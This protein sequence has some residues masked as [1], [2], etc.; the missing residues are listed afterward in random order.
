MTQFWTITDTLTGEVLCP[1]FQTESE[2]VHPRFRGWDWNPDR[3]KATRVSGVPNPVLQTWSGSAAA[4]IDDVAKMRDV[5]LA[6]VDQDREAARRP[7]MTQLLGQSFVYAEKAREVHDYENVVG[8]LLATLTMPQRAARFPFATAEAEATGDSL[9][10]VI[11]RFKAGIAASRA[12][13]A[14]ADALATK[15]KRAIRAATTPTQMQSA[16]TVA[17]PS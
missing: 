17:W 12:T 14:R 2:G 8:T 10:T 4:W 15:A 9:A 5:L 1:S 11:A 16:A 13:I 6:K 3:H 7:A